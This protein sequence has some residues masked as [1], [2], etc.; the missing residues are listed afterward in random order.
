MKQVGL[1]E[2]FNRIIDEAIKLKD[3]Y[4]KEKDLKV[5]W[6]CVFSQ[7]EDEYEKYIKEASEIGELIEK[8]P[9]GL[10]FKFKSPL[11]TKA[12]SPKIFKIREY[13]KTRTE[14]GDA[15]F[16]TNYPEF[17]KTYLDDNRFTL[18]PREKYEMIELK[19]NNFN[20]RVYFSSIP[21]SVLRNI[22]T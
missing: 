15:D 21:P 2:T 16:I 11:K 12:G 7:S 19:D 6:V 22:P 8:T 18:I 20:V 3:K 9:S 5:S 14:R 10:I 1:L 17:K 13:D 4:V